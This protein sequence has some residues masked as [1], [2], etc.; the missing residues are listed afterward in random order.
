MYKTVPLYVQYLGFVPTV[1]RDLEFVLQSLIAL[2]KVFQ[3]RLEVHTEAAA[4]GSHSQQRQV[5]LS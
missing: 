3:G 1:A 5:Q 2:P 4:T